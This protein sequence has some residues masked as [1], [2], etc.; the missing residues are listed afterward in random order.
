[1][2]SAR[3]PRLLA[4]LLTA[5]LAATLLIACGGDDDG[6]AVTP[7]TAPAEND[8]AFT[9]D[10]LRS[11]YLVG[12]DLTP[13]HDQLE[14]QVVAPAGI[15]VIDM[16]I[17]GQPGVRLVDSGADFRL[18]VDI[19]AIAAGER[20]L[21][22]A[23]DGSD[24][25]FARLTFNRSHPLYVLVGTDWDDPDSNDTSLGLQEDLHDEHAE[26][27]L[28]HFVGPYTFTAPE[29]SVERLAVLVAWLKDMRDSYDDELA[30]HIHPYCN[31]VDTTE[32]TCRTEPSVVYDAGDESGYTVESAAYTTEEYTTLLLATDALFEANGLGKPTSFRAGAWTA[33]LSTLQAVVAAGYT[34]DSNAYN[35]E[36]MEEWIDVGNGAFYEWVKDVWAPIGDTSQPYFPSE[37]DIAVAGEPALPVLEI[38][39]NG[40]MVDYV[41]A[42]EMKEIFAANWDGSALAAP[43]TYVI[44]L[45]PSNFVMQYKTSMTLAL[46][47]VDDH[48][49]SYG[50]GPVVYATMRDMTLV[51][52]QD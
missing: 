1:M 51:F 12:N 39:L 17:D 4:R 42:D 32:V 47:N 44:G 14:I 36:R 16:W 35:W 45:H 23:A 33:D 40:V 11:W 9:V 43:L 38:P 34:A 50:R 21:L 10:R 52:T 15:D 18:V 24:T 48:L 37:A 3:F 29:V 6:P 30:V 13:G 22:L 46:D 27:K 5:T 49:A 20:E 31:F 28:T 7:P 25:A 2:S 19:S 8:P 26:L 41:S